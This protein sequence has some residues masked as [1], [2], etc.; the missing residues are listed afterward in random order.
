MVRNADDL[1]DRPRSDWVTVT[2]LTPRLKSLLL[3]A[4]D[5]GGTV[6]GTTADQTELIRLGLAELSHSW[7]H[8]Y[9]ILN[10]AGL[11]QAESYAAELL[12][13]L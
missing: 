13:P 4:L 3:N 9:V 6:G 5:L 8:M 12:P 7:G 2:E 1:P 10:S 11:S